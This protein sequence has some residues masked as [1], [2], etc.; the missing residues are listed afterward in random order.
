[1]KGVVAVSPKYLGQAALKYRDNAEGISL[2]GVE[3]EAE[4][5]VMRVSEDVIEG[6]FLSLVHTR[7]GI[8][9]GIS[10]QKP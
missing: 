1:M 10:L 4:D 7:H 5:A 2:Q 8:V 3:P 6:N 9:L